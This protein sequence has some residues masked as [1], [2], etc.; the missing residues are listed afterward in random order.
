MEFSYH[1]GMNILVDDKL[2]SHKQQEEKRSS[3]RQAQQHATFL[4]VAVD[5][6]INSLDK[7][8]CVVMIGGVV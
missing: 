5:M 3:A 2:A 7:F 1:P 8:Y 6:P 4:N